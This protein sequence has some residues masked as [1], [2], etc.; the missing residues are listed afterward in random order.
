[1]ICAISSAPGGDGC[2]GNR[3]EISLGA[4]I[5]YTKDCL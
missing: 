3:G 1:L 5:E 4:I 2:V